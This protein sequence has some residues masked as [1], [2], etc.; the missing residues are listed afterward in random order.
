M[1][2]SKST[3]DTLARARA[4]TPPQFSI[5]INIYTQT[6]HAHPLHANTHAHN[7][8]NAYKHSQQHTHMHAHVNKQPNLGTHPPTN[9]PTHPPTD[10]PTHPPTHTRTHTHTHTNTQTHK[11]KGMR[12][13]AVQAH[14]YMQES[15]NIG[16][17]CAKP[18][19]PTVRSH[20]LVIRFVFLAS[21][22]KA[23]ASNPKMAVLMLNTKLLA[24]VQKHC[25]DKTSSL[26]M[27]L[28][29]LQ[30][31]MHSFVQSFYHSFL[32]SLHAF[33]HWFIHSFPVL[34]AIP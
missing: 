4:R 2:C 8:K 3:T 11:H 29:F 33:T 14:V 9:P 24:F 27:A 18:L 1:F 6:Q 16:E 25:R 32:H 22:A 10:P 5:Y 20:R 12:M 34:H 15:R 19:T 26:V 7:R 23:H 21:S 17:F 28:A 30:D 31:F 13:I